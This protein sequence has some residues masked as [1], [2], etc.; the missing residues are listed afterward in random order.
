MGQDWS[1]RGK[2]GADPE[3]SPKISP[4]AY[5][6]PDDARLSSERRTIQELTKR[7]SDAQQSVLGQARNQAKRES[8]CSS[9]TPAMDRSKAFDVS[10][11][12][13]PESRSGGH[14]V[15]SG[16]THWQSSAFVRVDES[17]GRKQWAC[18][19]SRDSTASGQ[20]NG[21]D[22]IRHTG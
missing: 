9:C 4:V 17:P 1:S 5:G 14:A 15:A 13:E 6:R 3:R 19:R 20:R 16:E 11:P 10:K 8:A 7:A 18:Q 22:V 2:Q 21:R 12:V